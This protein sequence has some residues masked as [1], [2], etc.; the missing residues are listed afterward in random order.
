MIIK[1]RK[2]GQKPTKSDIIRFGIGKMSVSYVISH[3]YLQQCLKI[4]DPIIF[5]HKEDYEDLLKNPY[6]FVDF[7]CEYF[8]IIDVLSPWG[9]SG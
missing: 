5:M 3:N 4:D 8:E 6:R 7:I 9:K 1:S 2:K